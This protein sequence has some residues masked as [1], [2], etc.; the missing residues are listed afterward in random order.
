M[1]LSLLAL[2]PRSAIGDDG[3]IALGHAIGAARLPVRAL[4]MQ[5]NH[6]SAEGAQ[7]LVEGLM[8]GGAPLEELSFVD[9]PIC[10]TSAIVCAVA[11]NPG[12]LASDARLP[13]C[14]RSCHTNREVRGS[15][16]ASTG[17]LYLTFD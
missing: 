8:S 15:G 4:R 16:V 13:G 1:P 6:V 12:P 10:L 14:L 9:N 5:T 7:A 11:S 3:A 17:A 2:S